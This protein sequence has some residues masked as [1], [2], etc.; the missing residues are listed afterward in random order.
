L[1]KYAYDRL[2]S[3]AYGLRIEFGVRVGVQRACSLLRIEVLKV[4]I[5][6]LEC[7]VRCAGTVSTVVTN[8]PVGAQEVTEPRKMNYM[9]IYSIYTHD[10]RQYTRKRK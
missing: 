8:P 5:E 9:A 6:Y 10:A 4:L 3:V 2:S 1:E 7:G